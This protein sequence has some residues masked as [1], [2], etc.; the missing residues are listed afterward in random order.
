VLTN[1]PSPN[2]SDPATVKALEDMLHSFGYQF[3]GNSTS[4]IGGIQ[5]RQYPVT[6]SLGGRPISGVV[7]YAAANQQIFGVTTLLGGGK[8]AAQDPELQTAASSVRFYA[9][10][11]APAPEASTAPA[12]PPAEHPAGKASSPA[13]TAS[14]PP[15]RKT[16]AGPDYTRLAIFAGV[17]LVLLLIVVKL[18]GG[19]GAPPKGPVRPPGRR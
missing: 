15:A 14:A 9:P 17:G 5:W 6:S 2:L 13:A 11:S 8:E 1:P 16:E 12:A 19:G 4:T 10:V 3:F 7:R 18:I